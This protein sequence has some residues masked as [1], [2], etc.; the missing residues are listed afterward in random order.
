MYG[1]LVRKEKARWG[2]RGLEMKEAV[3]RRGWS[4]D[5]PAGFAARGVQGQARW[6]P[7]LSIFQPQKCLI[8]SLLT[9]QHEPVL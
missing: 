1:W 5:A 7:R 2:G 4:G 6:Q 8:L 9:K 3:A